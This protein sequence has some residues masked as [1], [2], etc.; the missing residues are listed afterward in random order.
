MSQSQTLD[1][2]HEPESYGGHTEVKTSCLKVVE[3]NAQAIGCKYTFTDGS[4]KYTGTIGDIGITYL[5]L[6][7]SKIK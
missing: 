4:Q 5:S 1:T 2:F 3:D 6:G 7:I